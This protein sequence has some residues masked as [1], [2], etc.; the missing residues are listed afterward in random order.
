MGESLLRSL[1]CTPHGKLDCNDGTKYVFFFFGPDYDLSRRLVDLQA[2]QELTLQGFW[3]KR[4]PAAFI[5]RN[6]YLEEETKSSND[7]FFSLF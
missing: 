5:A 2:N 4:E 3:S 1:I 7:N 6:F